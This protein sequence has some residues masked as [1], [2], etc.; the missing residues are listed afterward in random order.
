MLLLPLVWGGSLG[1]RLELA[2]TGKQG[3]QA[4]MPENYQ[5][6]ETYMYIRCGNHQRVC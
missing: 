1:Q 2:N 6:K 3:S 4:G 5:G